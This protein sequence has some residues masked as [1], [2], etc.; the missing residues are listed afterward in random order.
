MKLYHFSKKKKKKKKFYFIEN[1]TK[2][3]RKKFKSQVRKN[4]Y[5]FIHKIIYF[6]NLDW[7]K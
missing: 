1:L 6:L 2:N 7:F 3:N 5:R 4:F